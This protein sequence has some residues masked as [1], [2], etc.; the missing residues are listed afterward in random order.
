MFALILALSISP[1]QKA[2]VQAPVQ[3]KVE[4]AHRPVRKSL[5]RINPFRGVCG[6]GSCG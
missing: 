2:Q 3:K 6:S 1:V 4:V 5:R